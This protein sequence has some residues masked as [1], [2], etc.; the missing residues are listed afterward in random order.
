MN[1]GTCG[2]SSVCFVVKTST[3]AHHRYMK[4]NSRL[5]LDFP[6]SMNFNPLSSCKLNLSAHTHSCMSHGCTTQCL[7]P[8]PPI[9]SSMSCL[10]PCHSNTAVSQLTELRQFL[11]HCSKCHLRMPIPVSVWGT[12][13]SG[14]GD[15][16]QL[17]RLKM[18]MRGSHVSLV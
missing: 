16:R 18:G 4:C 5:L 17:E 15:A 1:G 2:I 10:H 7:C 13:L 6:C 3:M 8:V 14:V 12:L 9:L 11:V